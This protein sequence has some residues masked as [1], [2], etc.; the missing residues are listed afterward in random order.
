LYI[1]DSDGSN[2]GLLT[3]YDFSEKNWRAD[4]DWSPDGR[5]IA[6]SERDRG[7]GRFQVKQIPARGG[8]PKLLTSEGENQQPSWAPDSRHVVFK[9]DRSGASQLWILDTES[10]RPRQLTKSAGPKLPAGSA[11]LL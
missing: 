2:D 6:Y 5:L 3:N 10:S 8:T 7:S 9:S 11:R 1:M 4:A